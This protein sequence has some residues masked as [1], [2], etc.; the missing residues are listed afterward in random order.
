MR[1]HSDMGIQ[2][3]ERAICLLTSLPSTLVHTLNLFIAPARSLMLLGAGNRDKR[4][5]LRK[6]MRILLGT[7]LSTGG[8]KKRIGRGKSYLSRSRS[9]TGRRARRAIAGG[10]VGSAGHPMGMSCVLLRPML[11]VAWGRV[12]LIM[13][14]LVRLWRIRRVG[15]IGRARG[16]NVWIYRHF[17]IRLD[18]LRMMMVVV[19]SILQ[20]H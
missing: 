2:M 18:V 13:V 19:L 20:G 4:I 17:G 1:L 6:R 3:I 9:R 11:R 5:N 16:R 12:A 15:R 14:H 8:K 10:A 7:R